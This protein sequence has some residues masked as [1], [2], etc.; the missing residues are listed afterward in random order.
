M[1]NKLIC[2]NRTA[3]IAEQ[4]KAVGYRNSVADLALLARWVPDNR[5][6]KKIYERLKIR[7]WYRMLQEIDTCI[8]IL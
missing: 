4:K 7:T 1:K 3:E 2:Q 5:Q 8:P 6:R